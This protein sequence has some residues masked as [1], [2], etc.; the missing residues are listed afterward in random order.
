MSL[1]LW[2]GLACGAGGGGADEGQVALSDTAAVPDSALPEMP[3]YPE[4]RRGHLVA[5]A[6]G[7]ADFA[8]AWR[9]RAGRCTDPPV[10]LVLAEAERS[11]ASILLELPRSDDLRGEYPVAPA[12]DAGPPDPPAARLG[13]QFFDD[14]PTAYQGAD[15]VVEIYGFASHV[16]GRFTATIRHVVS[17]EGARVAGVFHAVDIERLPEELCERREV[18]DSLD[19]GEGEGEG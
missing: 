8:M 7:A 1:A 5:R 13:F 11:G 18:L 10:L 3:D 17:H 16:S 2:F 14:A 4:P 12:G 19:E 15:G 9:A 6:V